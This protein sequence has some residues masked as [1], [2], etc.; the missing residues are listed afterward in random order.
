M[1]RQALDNHTRSGNGRLGLMYPPV[2]TLNIRMEF[3]SPEGHS[4]SSE[5]RQFSPSDLVDFSAPCQGRCGNGR[6]DLEGKISQIVNAGQTTCET[7]G[8]CQELLY[9]G[10]NDVCGCEL[11]C[12]IKVAYL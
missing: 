2:S 8:V 6:M 3:V 5:D 11:R 7:R 9:A 10:A 1:Q 12:V 4:L